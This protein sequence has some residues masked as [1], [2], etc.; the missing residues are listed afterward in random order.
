M[1]R[2]L[3]CLTLLTVLAAQDHTLRARGPLPVVEEV[4]WPALRQHCRELLEGLEALQAP[5][6][7]GTA[8]KL[9]LLLSRDADLAAAARAAQALLDPHCLAVV[10]INPESRVKA[11]QGP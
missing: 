10:T 11:V 9:R 4:E 5:L 3:C 7:P 2:R 8:E 6:P 1:P